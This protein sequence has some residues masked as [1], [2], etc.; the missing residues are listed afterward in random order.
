M[1]V[2]EFGL[3]L[4]SSAAETVSDFLLDLIVGY[5][6]RAAFIDRLAAGTNLAGRPTH[7]RFRQVG[8]VNSTVVAA[9]SSTPASML[10]GVVFIA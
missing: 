5:A 7:L 6:G 10:S 8:N 2:E 3:R 4:R 9:L 1:I